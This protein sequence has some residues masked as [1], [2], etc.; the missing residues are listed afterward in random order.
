M[1]LEHHFVVAVP[2]DTAWAALEDLPSIAPCFPGAEIADF[3]GEA[4]TG[5]CR[6]KLGPVSLQY[7]GSGRF[8]ERDAGSHRA[9]VE[10]RGKERRGNGTAAATITTSLAARDDATTAVTLATDLSVTGRPA[11][12]GRGMMQGVGD[13]LLSDFASC[14]EQTLAAAGTSTAAPVADD[15]PAEPTADEAPS[16]GSTSDGQSVTETTSAQPAASQNGSGSP[17]VHPAAL[18][19]GRTV[20]P[21]VLRRSAPYLALGAV[22]V[23]VLLKAFRRPR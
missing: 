9:V 10:I 15:Q 16:G 4:F 12:F 21:V 5:S 22:G 20:L 17:T 19:L 23:A 1:D 18:D 7:Q 3:D 11:Q 14:L 6:V 2:I 13:R 8:V